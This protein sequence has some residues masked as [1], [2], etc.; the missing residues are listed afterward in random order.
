MIQR[1]T[2]IRNLTEALCLPLHTEDYVIQSMPDVSP[3][4]WHL[5][6]TTWF[7][8]TFILVPFLKSYQV[9]CLEFNYIFNSYYES[10]GSRVQRCKRGILSR[11]T[12]EEVYQYRR[13]IDEKIAELLQC[14]SSSELRAIEPLLILGLNHEQQHQELLLTDIKHIFWTNSLRPTYHFFK[15]SDFP[16]SNEKLTDQFIYFTQGLYTIGHEGA[17]FAFDHEKPRHK[18]Y[19][20]EF[21][22]ESRLVTNGEFLEFMKAGGYQ[23]PSLW[24]SDGWNCVKKYGWNCPLYWEQQDDAWWSFTLLGMKRI[25]TNEPVCHVSYYEAAAFA[26]WRNARLPFEA[27]WEIAASLKKIEGNLLEKN[28]FHPIP[29]DTGLYSGLNR[30]ELK[31]FQFFGDVWEWTASSFQPYPGFN[32]YSGCIGEYNSKFMCNQITL[33]GGSCVTPTNH[34]RHT[35]RNFFAPETRWQ[36]TGFRLA[37]GR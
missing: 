5:G 8:E 33:R 36:F 13:L 30:D 23:T 6:H 3:P 4:K 31:L 9:Y 12:V 25:S 19:L 29:I 14:A 21:T 27:E 1:F 26:K 24:L 10:I 28:H 2:Q 17:G 20:E 37:K 35:Y 16:Q 22:I 32:P 34:I 18:V 15:N 7:L 11:P